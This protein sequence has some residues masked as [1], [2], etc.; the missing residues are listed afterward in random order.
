ML[1]RGSKMMQVGWFI[2][3]N[4]LFT[5]LYEYFGRN[6]EINAKHYLS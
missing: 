4:F 6:V 2:Y 3:D 1:K 5:I